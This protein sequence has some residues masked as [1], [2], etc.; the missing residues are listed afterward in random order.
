M[1]KLIATLAIAAIAL[2]STFAV[3]AFDGSSQKAPEMNVTLK[4]SLVPTAYDLSLT[5]GKD[6]LTSTSD[7]VIDGLDLTKEGKTDAFNVKISAGNLNKTITF[8]TEISELPFVGLVDGEEYTTNNNLSVRDYESG[9]KQTGFK[10]EIKAGPQEAQS[11]A[12]FNFQWDADT[13]LPAGDYAT[14]NKISISVN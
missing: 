11:I 13:S 14:T 8:V 2:T 5:Y 10:T 1:K 3:T 7:Y 4:S 6:S 9:T 12:V